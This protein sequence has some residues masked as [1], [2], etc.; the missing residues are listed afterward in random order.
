MFGRRREE[1]HEPKHVVPATLNLPPKPEDLQIVLK[2][3]ETKWEKSQHRW[4]KPH[5]VFAFAGP[6]ATAVTTI[7]AAFSASVAV[8]ATAGTIATLVTSFA[9]AGGFEARYRRLRSDRGKVLA[10]T[11]DL[12]SGKDPAVI[13]DELSDVVAA[14]YDSEESDRPTD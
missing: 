3:Y 5:L 13:W 4:K 14:H 8:T 7:L 11:V 2:E 10:L 1:N 12:Q 9:A 6:L